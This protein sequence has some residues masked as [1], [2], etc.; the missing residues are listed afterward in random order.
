MFKM[1]GQGWPDADPLGSGWS[2]AGH[3]LRGSRHPSMTCMTPLAASEK[4]VK[5]GTLWVIIV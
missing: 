3:L 2:S 5:M 1:L 4:T